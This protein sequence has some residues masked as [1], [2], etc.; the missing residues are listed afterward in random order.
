MAARPGSAYLGTFAAALAL[1]ATICTTSVQADDQDVVDYRRHIMKTLGE[2]TAV[3]GMMIREEVPSEDFATHVRVLAVAATTA[4]KAFEPNVA[5][6]DAKPDVWAH[7]PDFSDRLDQLV[8]A[9]EAL[10]KTAQEGGMA[11]AAPK[12]Q[13][14]LNCKSC[15]EVY[16]V[17]KK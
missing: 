5:G 8:A 10:A 11:A 12:L 9:T 4:R 3:L 16:R 2:Q 17:P 6:G 14:A 7:W 13:S 1:C 15:H